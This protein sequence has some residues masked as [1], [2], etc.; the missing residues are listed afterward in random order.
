MCRF[1]YDQ[2]SIECL[3]VNVSNKESFRLRAVNKVLRV[4]PTIDELQEDAGKDESE[5]TSKYCSPISNLGTFLQSNNGSKDGEY[6]LFNKTPTFDKLTYKRKKELNRTSGFQGFGDF[7][8]QDFTSEFSVNDTAGIGIKKYLEKQ[9]LEFDK[10][11]CREQEL[12]VIHK[13]Q[14][15][16]V[17]SWLHFFGK[18]EHISARNTRTSKTSYCVI[19][20]LMTLNVCWIIQER[21]H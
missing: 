17:Q 12:K 9:Q 2:C 15:P 14:C 7:F 5:T 13:N 6:W 10:L 16:E 8:P 1:T 21:L 4:L 20:T 19:R 18:P 11:N 3:T